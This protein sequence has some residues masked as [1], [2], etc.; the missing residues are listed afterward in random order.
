M[1]ARSVLQALNYDNFCS[2]FEHAYL[3]L[4]RENR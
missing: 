4:N 3:E 1:D 2:D